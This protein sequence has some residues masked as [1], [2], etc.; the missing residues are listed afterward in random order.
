M[1]NIHMRSSTKLVCPPWCILCVWVFCASSSLGW[2]RLPS[3]YCT[4]A[5]FDLGVVTPCGWWDDSCS[6]VDSTVCIRLAT[7]SLVFLCCVRTLRQIR[8]ASDPCVKRFLCAGPRTALDSTCRG[9]CST[10][11]LRSWSAGRSG[12]YVTEQRQSFVS[13]KPQKS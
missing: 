1:K 3:V 5:G 6:C 2:V 9:R 10:R 7:F 12:R 8:S 13:V 11:G 4:V